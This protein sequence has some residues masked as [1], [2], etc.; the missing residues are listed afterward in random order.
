MRLRYALTLILALAC[1]SAFAD[2]PAHTCQELHNY[3]ALGTLSDGAQSSAEREFAKR[4]A[5]DENGV[6]IDKPPTPVNTDPT[7]CENVR[8]APTEVTE[9][10]G[11]VEWALLGDVPAGAPHCRIPGGSATGRAFIGHDLDCEDGSHSAGHTGFSITIIDDDKGASWCSEPDPEEEPEPEN[12]QEDPPPDTQQPPGTQPPVENP[13]TST[14][15][16]SCDLV[17][18]G[19]PERVGVEVQLRDGA[20]GVRVRVQCGATWVTLSEHDNDGDGT[21]TRTVD[22]SRYEWCE[23][24]EQSLTLL[25]TSW[26]RTDSSW[27]PAVESAVCWSGERSEETE[28]SFV[29]A[30]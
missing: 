6:P 19:L 24:G 7:Y 9:G 11:W 29:C 23:D 1:T 30:E 10:D 26:R 20:T 5:Y 28:E 12:N 16:S 25:E 15:S 17:A 2:G 21:I 14:Q 27:E 4:C 18:T 8:I 13:P 22:F 3:I